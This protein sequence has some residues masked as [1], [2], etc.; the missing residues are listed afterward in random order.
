M[1]AVSIVDK[2][3]VKFQNLPQPELM[4][5]NEVKVQTRL[6]GICGSDMH[7]YHASNGLA[8]LPRIIGHEVCGEVTEV[9]DNVRTVAVGDHVVVDPISYCEKCYACR[10]G[11]PNI[12]EH[13]SVFGVHEDGGLRESF[14]LP[15]KNIWKM[16]K[17]IPWTDIVLAEPYTIGAQAV[18]RGKVQPGD[19]VFIQGAGPIGLCIMRMAKIRGAQVIISDMLPERLEFAKQQGADHVISAKNQNAL[20]EIDFWTEG[21]GANVVIDSVCLKSTF[22]LG[23]E[24]A[25]IGGRVVTLSFDSLPAAIPQAPITR[26]ELDIVGSRLQTH[27]FGDVVRMINNGQLR[28]DGLVSHT[29]S[30]QDSAEAFQFVESSPSA[31]RKA[32]IEVTK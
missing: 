26:K 13:L 1:K 15:E 14:I 18:S 30:F 5:S 8:D 10:K 22:E 17:D 20:E 2:Q 24:A 6:V 27:Q 28:S 7:I 31:V 9:G 19:R 25:S 23:I 21:E 32:V 16:N 11:R 4:G 29:F 12:C 3:K